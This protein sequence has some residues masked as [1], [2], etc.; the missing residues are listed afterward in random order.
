MQR[1]GR[2]RPALQ[3]H[4]LV[5]EPDTRHVRRE[6]GH[7]RV[8]PREKRGRARQLA[9]IA[10]FQCGDE[11]FERFTEQETDF[12][13]GLFLGRVQ[14][15]RGQ[16]GRRRNGHRRGERERG[17]KEQRVGKARGG[18]PAGVVQR[19][20]GLAQR[21][22]DV[23]LLVERGKRLGERAERER[24]RAAARIRQR[25]EPHIRA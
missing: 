5:G 18:K 2:K 9:Q 22:G 12:G 15:P 1:G 24:H 10:A 6:R 3:R 11:F 13:A 19:A 4:V 20:G 21:P 17:S 8:L 16:A 23:A 25:F 14:W 7:H